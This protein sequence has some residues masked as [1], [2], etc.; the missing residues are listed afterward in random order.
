MISIYVRIPELDDEFPC[1]GIGDMCDHVGEER[2]GRDVER[3]SEAEISG[4]LKHEAGEP[5]FLAWFLRKVDIK[6]AHH[7]AWW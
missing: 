7:M 2:V 3:D 4:P 5:R 6:L 1:F